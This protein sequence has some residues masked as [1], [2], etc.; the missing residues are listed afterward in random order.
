M[1]YNICKNIFPKNKKDNI[2]IICSDM[3][4]SKSD[5]NVQK[6]IISDSFNINFDNYNLFWLNHNKKFP[7]DSK[8]ISYKYIWFCGC[9]VLQWIFGHDKIDLIIEFF[10][11]QVT[12]CILF[13]TESYNYI[14]K[15][16]SNLIFY[17]FIKYNDIKILQFIDSYNFT[18]NQKYKI[19][20]YKIIDNYFKDNFE[21]SKIEH[22]LFYIKI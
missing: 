10:S 1:F 7:Q 8:K 4:N 9:N 11:S 12:N 15:S 14:K 13:F 18:K 16:K 21:F 6:Y 17:P 19:E 20:W 22:K 3:K 2:L 5:F